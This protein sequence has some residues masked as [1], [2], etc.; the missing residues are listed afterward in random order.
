MKKL[1]IQIFT[2]ILLIV[3][4]ILIFYIAVKTKTE[5][6]EKREKQVNTFSLDNANGSGIVG[7][8]IFND[9]ND[10]NTGKQNPEEAS[11]EYDSYSSQEPVEK[12]TI[13]EVYNLPVSSIS[14]SKDKIIFTDRANGYS[15]TKTSITSKNKRLD[16]NALTQV[17]NSQYSDN[18][19]LREILDENLQVKYDL[20]KINDKDTILDLDP[21]LKECTLTKDDKL[22]CIRDTENLSQI[23]LFDLNQ[24]EVKPR[25]L[26][27]TNLSHWQIQYQDNTLYLLQTPSASKEG[28]FV[29]IKDLKA[30]VQD[31][32]IGL[33]SKIS[34]DSK[35]LL[36]S[37]FI[38]GVLALQ[39]KNLEKNS[40]T[41]IPLQTLAS[42]CAF[43]KNAIICAVPK[44]TPKG[45]VFLDDWLKGKFNFDDTFYHISLDD[46]TYEK[47]EIVNMPKSNI[48][49]SKLSYSKELNTLAFVNKFN[50][51]AWVLELPKQTKVKETTEEL[52]SASSTEEIQIKL[53]RNEI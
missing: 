40:V 32:G 17:Y 38:N 22:L 14:F 39:I 48:D 2:V 33:I 7:G 31:K 10:S 16:Q 21:A 49:V 52:D 5:K 27:A 42:K 26:F 36:S 3:S 9:K 6:I 37:K 23:I 24:E 20:E 11:D 44:S 35:Y 1:Y 28:L 18:Y 15:F 19:I 50:L 45:F 51:K 13:Q 4:A 29:K 43:A 12:A 25:V 8:T 47:M 34:P 30:E 41:D 46:F 53:K